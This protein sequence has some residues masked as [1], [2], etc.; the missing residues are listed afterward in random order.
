MND[1]I[2]KNIDELINIAVEATINEINDTGS[3]D[4][5][6]LNAVTELIRVKGDID[7]GFRCV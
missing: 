6:K 7:I 5:E 1:A 3:F 2:L 4:A